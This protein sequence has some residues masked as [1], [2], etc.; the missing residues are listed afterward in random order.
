MALRLP[1]VVLLATLVTLAGCGDTLGSTSTGDTLTP[2]AVPSDSPTP[3]VTPTA[4]TGS[5]ATTGTGETRPPTAS[6]PEPRYLS[7]RPTCERPPGL[8]VA[9]QVGALRNDPPD[10][11]EGINTTWQFAT[12]QTR[13]TIGS[14][15][16][17]VDV[18]ERGYEPLLTAETV[19]YGPLTGEDGFV[20]TRVT[21]RNGSR[22]TT[23]RWVLE[24]QSVGPRA[25]CWLTAAVFE[26]EN[27]ARTP[28]DGPR[29][30]GPSPSRS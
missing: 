2:V 4:T 11:D 20:S 19:T 18:I 5:P 7:L 21:V 1:V 24:R 3:R 10:S 30:S 9:I 13:Q 23:Y 17:F 28:D 22:S 14:L 27:P 12:P 8:V 15:E 26:V 25:G 29:T 16:R 6:V